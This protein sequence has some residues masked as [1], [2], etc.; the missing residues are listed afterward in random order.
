MTFHKSRRDDYQT[1]PFKF[2]VALNQF[3][4][5]QQDIKF[6]YNA[7][8]G[9][10]QEDIWTTGGILSYLSSA[11]LMSIVS[12]DANDAAAG[13]GAQTIQIEGLDGAWAPITEV[14]TMDGLTPVLTTQAF[15]RVNRMFVLTAGSGAEN[16]GIISATAQT[17]AT[18]QAEI[19]ATEN[20]SMKIQFSVPLGQTAFLLGGEMGIAAATDTLFRTKI[21][22]FGSVFRTKHILGIQLDAQATILPVPEIIPAQSDVTITAQ[23]SAGT[24]D[25]S[26]TLFYYFVDERE[27]E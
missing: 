16:A 9:T 15:L 20:Q 26:A 25:C 19:A 13:T 11:E 12:T 27:G 4:R 18:V 3:P 8:V 7:T 17:S 10:T 22:E 5:Y 6:G 23:A 14:V 24:V 1:I 21:R 2:R